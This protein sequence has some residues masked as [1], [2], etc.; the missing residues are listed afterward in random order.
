MKKKTYQFGIA[1]EKLVILFLRLKGYKIL[2]W[3]FK[4]KVGE[5]DIIATK[6]NIIIAI[7]VKARKSKVLLE[8]ILQNRQIARVK[9]ATEFFIAKHRKYDNMAIR[10]DF[11]EVNRFFIPTHNKNFF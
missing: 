6:S 9:R 5:V 8:E 1:A 4:T 2:A 7:E 3:R 10:F 11:I